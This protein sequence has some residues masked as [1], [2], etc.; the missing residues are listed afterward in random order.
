M[1]D[2]KRGCYVASAK[3]NH[4]YYTNVCEASIRVGI[5]T[6]ETPWF[7]SQAPPPCRLQGTRKRKINKWK[8][9]VDRRLWVFGLW[10]VSIYCTV[11]P[12]DFVLQYIDY[13]VEVVWEVMRSDGVWRDGR[14]TAAAVSLYTMEWMCISCR[15]RCQRDESFCMNNISWIVEQDSK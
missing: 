4:L 5:W 10:F 7:E 6:R 11:L 12:C 9:K 8:N 15:E 2:G 13:S 3:T 1:A 14:L